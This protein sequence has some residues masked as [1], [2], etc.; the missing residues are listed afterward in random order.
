VNQS[1]TCNAFYTGNSTNF[2][3]KGGGC[4]N[5]SYSSVVT[6]EMG[7][8]LV[9]KLNLN[10][11]AFGEGVGDIIG[12]LMYNDPMTGRDFFAVGE[13]LR[14]PVAANKQYPC[15]DEIH[16]CGMV[17]SGVWW[18]IH[19]NLGEDVMLPTVQQLWV[20]WMMMTEGEEDFSDGIGPSNVPEV[21]LVADDDSDPDTKGPYDD[22]ICSAFVKHGIVPCGD[23]TLLNFE[24]VNI[25]PGTL[26]GLPCDT[27]MT[28]CAKVTDGSL[29][30]LDPST[31]QLIYK[32]TT[33]GTPIVFLTMTETSPSI[34]EGTIPATP[35]G[36]SFGFYFRAETTD[37]IVVNVP[38]GA[39]KNRYQLTTDCAQPPLPSCDLPP[40]C[41]G[42]V[43]GDNVV[44]PL[45]SGYSLARF[46][47]PVGTG[48]PEC[49]AAD[50]N[51]DGVVDP[52]DTGFILARFGACP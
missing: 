7:H 15:N 20:D 27:D 25:D 42:D 23:I 46:G 40:A 31:V 51:V 44:D 32:N 38:A 6:H 13:I 39:P 36:K 17:L 16:E 24:F 4:P 22:A 2:F 34:F 10:Q 28:F 12:G 11:N 41:E 29:G 45:D 21:L 48:D 33:D 1:S 14:N 37:G 52:L 8:Y 50:A 43:N 49:D 19:M 30:T 18:D 9:E 47:C 3:K 26:T 5:T 35:A